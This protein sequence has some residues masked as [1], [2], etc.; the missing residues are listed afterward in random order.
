MSPPSP[1]LGIVTESLEQRVARIAE[2]T[3]ADQQFVTPID[4]LVGLGCLDQKKAGI[5]RMGLVTS[6][7]RCLR[8]AP[9]DALTAL[10][11]WA[12]RSGLREW[13][14]AYGGLSFTA[15]ADPCTEREFRIRWAAAEEPL[16]KR[17]PTRSSHPRL[18]AV[19]HA[20][21]CGTCERT[22][23]LVLNDKT[24]RVCLDCAGLGHLVFLR[25]G[26][27]ALTRRTTK[28]APCSAVVVR[29]NTRRMRYDRHG[30]LADQRSIELA[31]GQCLRD[32]DRAR[33]RGAVNEDLRREI[34]D[35]ITTTFPGC[36]PARADA[37]AYYA[38][39]CGRGRHARAGG[40]LPES[41]RLA[42][43]SSVRRINTDYDDLSLRGLDQVEAQR[44]T[45]A[46]V[47]DILGTWRGGIV[48]LDA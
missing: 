5:W 44:R 3:L 28:A 27:A 8:A 9:D 21:E 16:P 17:P 39:V 12:Q 48:L 29:M 47:D 15:D 18:L 34:A 36:P 23:D 4:V 46:Q 33:S 1:T 43:A 32:P 26:D 2:S 19:D 7:D 25:S 24:G 37:I 11:T 40:A 35:T 20:W 13:E 14:T 6:L 45:Q 42:V 38:A 30:V 22:S 31:A 10:R 41:L